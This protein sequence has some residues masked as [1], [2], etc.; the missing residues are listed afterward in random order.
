MRKVL[1][2]LFAVISFF[3]VG[4]NIVIPDAGF[5]AFLVANFDTDGDREIS[6]AEANVVE[7]MKLSTVDIVSLEGIAYFQYLEELECSPQN[8]FE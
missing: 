8:L 7:R 1:T 3:A 6:V 5:K 2:I 4:Q